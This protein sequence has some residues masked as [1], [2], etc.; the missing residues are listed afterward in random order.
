MMRGVRTM[1]YKNT[2]EGRI[3]SQKYLSNGMGA[4]LQ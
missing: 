4:A 3:V 2:S 1:D